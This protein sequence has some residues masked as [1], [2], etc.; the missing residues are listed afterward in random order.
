MAEQLTTYMLR[1]PDIPLPMDRDK[2]YKQQTQSIDKTGKPVRSVEIIAL[3]LF[4]RDKEIILQ[5]RSHLKTHNPFLIDKAVGG[6][7]KFGDSPIFTLM[8][9][10]VQELR[11]PSIVLRNDDDF[12][13]TYALLNSYIDSVAIIEELE[14]VNMNLERKIGEKVYKLPHVVHLYIGI[15]GGSS[16]PVDKEASGILYYNMDIL[17]KEMKANSD[18]FTQDLHMYMDKYRDKID[19]FLKKVE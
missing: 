7:I 6:H 12:R 14:K 13:K 5:K 18:A 11:V 19:E 3:L 2:F 17:E 1:D 10:T 8:V 16:R 9:E 15:Y 4:N